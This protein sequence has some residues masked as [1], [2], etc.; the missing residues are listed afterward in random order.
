[1]TDRFQMDPGEVQSIR[2]QE[3][4]RADGLRE[5]GIPHYDWL[6]QFPDSYGK[7]AWPV[8]QALNRYYAERERAFNALADQHRK[9]ADA[10]G[11]FLINMQRTDEDGA[12]DIR[13]AFNDGPR[14]PATGA[15]PPAGGPPP[16]GGVPDGGPG[17]GVVVTPTG[18]PGTTPSVGAT[19]VGSGPVGSGAPDR[20]ASQPAAAANGPNG[21][22]LAGAPGAV[23]AG[24]IPSGTGDGAPGTHGQ[25]QHRQTAP[26]AGAQPPAGGPPGG[27]PPGGGPGPSVVVPPTAPPGTTPPVAATPN[28]QVP[29]APVADTPNGQVPGEPVSPVPVFA[30]AAPAERERGTEPSQAG[31]PEG[32]D[33]LLLARTLLAS[34]L[35]AV[36]EGGTRQSTSRVDWAVSVMRG[37]GGPSVFVTTNEGRGW[38]PAGLF[39]PQEVSVPWWSE[40][41]DAA[42]AGEN[43]AD[44]AHALVEF[45]R[46]WGE[47]SGARLTALVSSAGIDDELRALVGESVD[48]EANIGPARSDVDLAAPG[49]GLVDRLKAT[50][51]A[52]GDVPE[53]QVMAHCLRL[54]ADAHAQVVR[55][56]AGLERT[57][58]EVAV[59]RGLRE[60]ICAAIEAGRDVPEQL[61]Q[62]LRNA[63]AAVEA[64]LAAYR[65]HAGGV[66]RGN[67]RLDRPS[68]VRQLL[69]ER[70]CNE[71]VLLL[72]NG[73]SQQTLRDVTYSHGQVVDHPALGRAPVVAAQA[74]GDR[75]V[76]A[77]PGGVLAPPVSPPAATPRTSS[78][79]DQAVWS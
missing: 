45:A 47:R 11:T 1:M 20:T 37:A 53:N 64:S 25:S 52:A 39:L 17:P 10:L 5:A 34:V 2:G 19:P 60:Q 40:V 44:P 74:T 58:G 35:A 67:V 56:V 76:V 7:T 43:I 55:T 46:A 31:D 24:L 48:V 6:A 38:L 78:A 12:H 65:S 50:G 3:Y 27:G 68:V 54:A 66:D 23:P 63:D 28:G 57:A 69:F 18:P 4:A 16:G 29:G 51:G 8:L 75:P 70:R 26:V 73:A 41:A 71:L 22:E 9:M 62:D 13:N 77:A 32:H 72:A 15:Q 61:W 33:D 21:A 30:G 59:A 42:P 79:D 49:A 36:A 14:E